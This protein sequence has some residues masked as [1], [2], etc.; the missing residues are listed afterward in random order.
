MTGRTFDDWLPFCSTVSAKT[1]E[2]LDVDP[3][4]VDDDAPPCLMA[5]SIAIELVANIAIIPTHKMKRNSLHD[6]GVDLNNHE[7]LANGA[8]RTGFAAS[9]S[10]MASILRA[11]FC[12]IRTPF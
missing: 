4:T 10:Y 8:S 7:I 9:S 5:S 1:S 6:N 3:S 2:F 12:A 11:I